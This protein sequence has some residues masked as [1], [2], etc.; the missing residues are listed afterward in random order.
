MIQQ[1]TVLVVADN[2]GAKSVR[3]IK[4]L[5]GPKRRYANVGDII[6]VS[7]I[8]ALP[9]GRV[10]KGDVCYA[11]VVRTKKGVRRPE[12]SV[13][14]SDDNAVVLLNNQKQMIGTRVFGPVK[15]ELRV[16][17]FM[18]IVSLAPGVL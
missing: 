12:G 18:K 6:R 5:G 4:V 8:A 15:R 7:V 17:K 3:C 2:S 13:I 9:K 1:S 16:E 11:V 10:S 14:R